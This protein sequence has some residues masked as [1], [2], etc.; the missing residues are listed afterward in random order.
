MSQ[1]K[2]LPLNCSCQIFRSQRGGTDCW[3]KDSSWSQRALLKDSGATT[4]EKDLEAGHGLNS[5]GD[6]L[7]GGGWGLT[8]F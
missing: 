4:A 2:L 1:N 6:V 8:D 5:A 3:L 7:R